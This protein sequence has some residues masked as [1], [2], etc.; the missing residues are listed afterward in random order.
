M[1]IATSFAVLLNLNPFKHEPPSACD[2]VAVEGTVDADGD[3]L[4]LFGVLI[5]YNTSKQDQ[6]ETLE[7]RPS[8]PVK[9]SEIRGATSRMDADFTVPPTLPSPTS[10]NLDVLFV[11]VI[12]TFAGGLTEGVLALPTDGSPATV[13]LGET[14]VTAQ[15]LEVDATTG[16]YRIEA[17]VD[18][19]TEFPAKANFSAD[20]DGDGTN[21]LFFT[22][23]PVT[24]SLSIETEL[25]GEDV[26]DGDTVTAEVDIGGDLQTVESAVVKEPGRVTRVQVKA[27]GTVVVDALEGIPGQATV[28]VFTHTDAD[29]NVLD[30]V[31]L[32]VVGRDGAY[33]SA[34][35]NGDELSVGPKKLG[36]AGKRGIDGVY[37]A[38]A[39]DGAWID[40]ALLSVPVGVT[41]VRGSVALTVSP[42]GPVD[43][44]ETLASGVDH[45]QVELFDA[46]GR[47]ITAA[48]PVR[49]DQ[50][51]AAA[52]MKGGLVG[53]YSFDD[54]HALDVSLYEGPG[55]EGFVC[56]VT[57]HF[58][59]DQFGEILIDGVVWEVE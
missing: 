44:N 37:D 6:P 26:E 31:E 40:A 22:G 24:Q 52:R 4:R 1:V 28:A 19:A 45:L 14:L 23:L 30:E 8:T 51:Y 48:G 25:C 29:G 15:L 46:N 56:G 2:T 33:S 47:P 9:D 32:P 36:N 58:K 39:A 41:S 55:K 7:L 12:L 27:D 54:G 10:G 35:F 13:Q 38:L 11:D 42:V 43:W 57:D 34:W 50:S 21:D 59:I 18:H 3:Q 16:A 20:L 17:T 53:G 5:A 49:L